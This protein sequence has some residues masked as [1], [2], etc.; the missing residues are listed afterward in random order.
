M[1]MIIMT[2]LDPNTLEEIVV[3][4]PERELK[5]IYSAVALGKGGH[6]DFLVLFAR[7]F[8]HAD[9]VN[10]HLLLPVARTLVER[11]GLTK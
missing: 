8:L 6:G 11:Y 2:E 10:T 4:H 7:A 9:Y 3:G 5:E 1:G